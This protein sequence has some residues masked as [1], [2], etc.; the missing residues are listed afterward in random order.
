MSR[1]DNL[2]HFSIVI[3]LVFLLSECTD[4]EK[5]NF[6]S[7]YKKKSA[8]I[9]SDDEYKSLYK[10]IN[11]SVSNWINHG[12]E[13]YGVYELN[14]TV[15]IDS[16]LCLNSHGTKFVSAKLA[17]HVNEISNSDGIDFFYGAKI[18]NR[19]YFFEGAHIV[20]PRENF[21]KD[22]HTPLSFSKLHE[23]AMQEVFSGYLVR[24]KKDAGFWKNIFAPEYEYEVNERF[25]DFENKNQSGEG[26]GS[27][28]KCKTFEEYVLYLV[29]ENWKKR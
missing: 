9:I 11:D 17:R 7:L 13:Y 23:I 6:T 18:K 5:T 25:F 16:L 19:W 4:N 26:Y 28:L 29:G 24:K 27:C 14:K 21:Q 8:Q 2:K 15:M 22:I 10:I 20:L 12:I 1:K 3:F